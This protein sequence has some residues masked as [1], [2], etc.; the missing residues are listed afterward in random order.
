MNVARALPHNLNLSEGH[1]PR[2][3]VAPKLYPA[4]MW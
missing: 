3:S 4:D 1:K 2:S